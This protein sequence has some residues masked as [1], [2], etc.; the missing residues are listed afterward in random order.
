MKMLTTL[1]CTLLFATSLN[2]AE[3][4]SKVMKVSDIVIEDSN[5]RMARL[6]MKLE[7]TGAV[8]HTLVAAYAPIAEQTQLHACD[9]VEGKSV[10][11]QIS[12]L[13]VPAKGETIL[14]SSGLHVM[15]MGME[16]PLKKG[17]TV[18][19]RLIFNDG[20]NLLIEAKAEPGKK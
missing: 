15:L 20:S 10:M 3:L 17:D 6:G 5:G 4:A 8:A 16:A 18:P 12:G 2:A 7:N 14:S 13:T 1:L 19:V 11:R 9:M